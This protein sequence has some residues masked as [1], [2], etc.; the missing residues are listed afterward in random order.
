MLV[1]QQFGPFTIDKELGS[2]AMGTVY[3]GRFSKTGQI[4]AIKIMAPGVGSTS[5]GAVDRFEREIA[6]L[7]QLNHPNIV[8]FHG[9]GKEK[10]MRYFAMEYIQGE[11]L[12]KVMARR[13][14]M[15]WEEV[16]E[17]G[18]QL[19]S[20]LKHAHDKGIV[21]RDLKPSNIMVLPDG[22]LKLTD[23]GI[24]KAATLDALTATNCTVGTASYMSPEQCKGVQDLTHKSDLYSLG[25]M[26][27]ELVTGRKPFQAENA[28]DMFMLHVNGTFER[29][30]H[31]VLD[32]PIW[33]DTLIC[34]LLEKKPEQRPLDAETVAKALGS[35]QEKV[36][37]QQSAGVEAVRRR[38]IDRRPGQKRLDDEDKEAARTLMTGKGKAKRKQTVKPLHQRVWVQALGL[39]FGLGLVGTLLYLVFRSPPTDKLYQQAKAVME[40]GSFADQEKAI[41]PDGVISKCLRAYHKQ[42]NEQSREVRGW[43]LQIQSTQNERLLDN[44]M[45][46]RSAVLKFEAQNKTQESAFAAM[47]A[48]EEGDQ[49]AAIKQWQAVKDLEGG[50]SG[51]S[52]V[53]DKHLA[54]WTALDMLDKE[55][56]RLYER[57]HTSGEEPSLKDDRQ[58][59]AFRAWRE[60]HS[61]VGDAGMAKLF[62]KSLKEDLAKEPR[63]RTH[64]YLFAAVNARRLNDKELD[65]EQLK[66]KVGACLQ[67]VSEQLAMK[68]PQIRALDARFVCLDVLA[69]YSQEE[70]MNTVVKEAEKLLHDIPQ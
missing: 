70:W 37:S 53:A 69:L 19:C 66:K 32:L 44:Y 42:D 68:P 41:E 7:K 2:G 10:G 29:P 23:F 13:G 61:A 50:G 35:I 17:L 43:L 63:P 12:D 36:E 67:M 47:E 21:H 4:M 31:L 16:V 28:M 59:Q 65:K 11:S 20:A 57:I 18:Q 9:A 25:V 48:E 56:Q 51:W 33:L 55:F 22:T 64:W 8:R 58:I 30:S 54:A 3:R 52:R 27:Y 38:L 49:E 34:Q 24:A 1:G 45:Q 26:F 39:L 62:Y 6:I 15:T 14:R 60:E 40:S 46:K 5:S